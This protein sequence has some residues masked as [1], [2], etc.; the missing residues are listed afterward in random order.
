M[1]RGASAA[2]VARDGSGS[3]ASRH[4]PYF[5]HLTPCSSR[6]AAFAMPRQ[7]E[8]QPSR[9]GCWPSRGRGTTI[10]ARQP[11]KARRCTRIRR[12]GG[13]LDPACVR[14]R[15]GAQIPACNQPTAR[16]SRRRTRGE[17]AGGTRGGLG[18]PWPPGG[19]QA[20]PS[21][22]RHA[23]GL[24]QIEHPAEA[25]EHHPRRITWPT[26]TLIILPHLDPHEAIDPRPRS[27]VRVS[28]ARHTVLKGSA[29]VGHHMHTNAHFWTVG[30]RASAAPRRAPP[31]CTTCTAGAPPSSRRAAA[32]TN[33]LPR[34]ECGLYPVGGLGLD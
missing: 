9:P 10:M 14:V 15:A 24:A 18:G 13:L 7:A 34:P 4:R 21:R 33:P 31:T 8:Q 5:N 2:A 11:C 29:P 12:R 26:P 28:Q 32:P 23:P 30:P 25:I 3:C 6:A 17:L 22:Q 1:Q 19:L 16:R 20:A 27:R